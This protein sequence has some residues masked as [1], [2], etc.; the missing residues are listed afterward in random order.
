MVKSEEELQELIER[1]YTYKRG[2]TR[3]TIRHELEFAQRYEAEHP[4]L[5]LKHNG[6]N[7]S[8]DF[9]VVQ[10]RELIGL[11]EFKTQGFVPNSR[12]QALGLDKYLKA[13]NVE[14]HLWLPTLIVFRWLPEKEGIY[15]TWEPFEPDPTRD[16]KLRRKQVKF[17]W[18]NAK[19][20][21]HS[22]PCVWIPTDDLTL[23]EI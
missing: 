2:R 11:I 22:N 8:F 19:S 21:N 10:D 13:V 3:D 23:L 6:Q 7:H 14:Q 15:H 4:H 12:K 16:L 1:Q 20:T 9:S 5:E 18:V 17:G